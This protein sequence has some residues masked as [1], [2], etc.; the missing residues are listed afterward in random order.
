ME[1]R[2]QL[3]K[4]QAY[5]IASANEKVKEIQV[6]LQSLLRDVAIELGIDI[7]DPKSGRWKLSEDN[8]FLERVDIQDVKEKDKGKVT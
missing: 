5:A 3:T 4:I 2:K 1:S 8:L 7:D 6:E